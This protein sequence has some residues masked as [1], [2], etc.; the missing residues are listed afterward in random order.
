MSAEKTNL[1]LVEDVS[2]HSGAEGKA[3][4]NTGRDMGRVAIIVSLLSVVLLV[5]FFFGL[6]RNLAGVTEEVKA[7]RGLQSDVQVLGKRVD[8]LEELPVHIQYGMATEMETK[9]VLLARQVT[10]PHQMER[11]QKVRALLLEFKN[12]LVKK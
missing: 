7:L 2:G 9:S 5:I 4:E 3:K 10:D 1:H 12:E 11:L 6:N 8:T